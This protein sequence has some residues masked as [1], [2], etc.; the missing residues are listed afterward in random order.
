MII[1]V[2]K[3]NITCNMFRILEHYCVTSLTER[4]E[5]R[6]LLTFTNIY[7]SVGRGKY[8]CVTSLYSL[9]GLLDD[10]MKS[11]KQTNKQT[12]KQTIKA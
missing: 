4:H 7:I 1:M 9:Y 5:V 11:Q 2:L 3:R 12:N 6:C 10:V 8:V